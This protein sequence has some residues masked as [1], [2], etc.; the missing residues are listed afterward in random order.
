MAHRGCVQGR[1]GD[2]RVYRGSV[3]WHTGDVQRMTG[4]FY[5]DRG[6]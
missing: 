1:T 3:Q 5:T 4:D 2:D 6:F